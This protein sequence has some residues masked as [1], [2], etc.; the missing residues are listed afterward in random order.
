MAGCGGTGARTP[1]RQTF[2]CCATAASGKAAA[3]P[4]SVMNSR[5]RM[6][7]PRT[8]ST[9]Y[10]IIG[11]RGRCA[12]QRNFP[13]F[14]G[15]GSGP[16]DSALPRHVGFPLDCD[17]NSDLPGSRK[18]PIGDMALNAGSVAYAAFWFLATRLHSSLLFLY[19]PV[20]I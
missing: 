2:G 17:R 5:R 11:R 15:S 18:V 6:T 10:H 12:L 8:R 7:C 20:I 19:Q 14:V 16:T 3:A 1:M 4:N 9:S 13:A